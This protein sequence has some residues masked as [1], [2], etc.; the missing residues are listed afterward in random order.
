MDQGQSNEKIACSVE[1]IIS[2]GQTGV[3]LAAIDAAIA[4]S[5]DWGG[6]V[7]RGRRNEDGIIPAQY[8]QFAELDTT[9]YSERTLANVLSSDGTLIIVGSKRLQGGTEFTFQQALAKKKPV[10]VCLYPLEGDRAEHLRHWIN[11]YGIKVLNVAGPRHSQ[12][13]E[14]GAQV[15]PIL[16]SLF[17]S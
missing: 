9:Q 11:T 5:L 14:A 10:F 12:D 3:D 13:G 15:L 8:D 6:F 17:E 4:L 1:K 2:G 16:K 7:P